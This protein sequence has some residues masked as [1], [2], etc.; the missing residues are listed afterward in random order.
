MSSEIFFSYRSPFVSSRDWGCIEGGK[1]GPVDHPKRPEGCDAGGPRAPLARFAWSDG[2]N[3][4][5]AVCSSS[6]WYVDAETSFTVGNVVVP[7][8]TWSSCAAAAAATAAAAAAA[9]FVFASF[10]SKI[11]LIWKDVLAGIF[12]LSNILKHENNLQLN[13]NEYKYSIFVEHEI[14]S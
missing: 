9:A 2:C 13:F 1:V 7:P 11:S 14:Y 12:M 4:A 8:W 6:C 10:N 5:D 3:I